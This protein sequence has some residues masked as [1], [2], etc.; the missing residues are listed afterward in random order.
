MRR[1][2][3]GTGWNE[4]TLHGNRFLNHPSH[5]GYDWK[6]ARKRRGEKN[7]AAAKKGA[8]EVMNREM[9]LTIRLLIVNTEE[10][11]RAS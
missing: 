9:I 3:V 10:E 1:N 4:S 11:H 6:Q 2:L 7:I 5:P 8:P